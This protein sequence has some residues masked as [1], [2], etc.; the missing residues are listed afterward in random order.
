MASVVRKFRFL[1]TAQ[2]KRLHIMMVDSTQ[3]AQPGLLESA[4]HSPINIKHYNNE[5]NLFLLAASLSEKIMKNHAYQD[6]NKRTALLAADMFLKI[7][8]YELQQTPLQPGT[9]TQELEKAH[10]A[11]CTNEWTAEDLARFYEQIAKATPSFTPDVMS[12]MNDA[13]EC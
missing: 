1:T 5:Q 8:G 12:Y 2:V 6:G 11:V 13:T 3:P 10:V 7:N 4:V 9:I